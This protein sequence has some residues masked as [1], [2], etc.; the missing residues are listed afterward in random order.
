M[1]VDSENRLSFLGGGMLDEGQSMRIS[2][3]R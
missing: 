2:A 1:S 3:H